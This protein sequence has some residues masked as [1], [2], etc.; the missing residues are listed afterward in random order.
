[1]ACRVCRV[2]RGLDGKWGGGG[3]GVGVGHGREGKGPVVWRG[4]IG[5]SV[6]KGWGGWRG[7]EKRG[8]GLGVAVR[9]SLAW[10]EGEMFG[11]RMALVD[12]R[13]RGLA[14]LVFGSICATFAGSTLLSLFSASVF[15]CYRRDL[16]YIPEQSYMLSLSRN[17][18]SGTCCGT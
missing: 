7:G 11:W 6:R 16:L 17:P 15:A 13:E 14:P 10:E 12:G 5:Y 18:R 9:W 4:R 8:R 3:A 2:W 1:M